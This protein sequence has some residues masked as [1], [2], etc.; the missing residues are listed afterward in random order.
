MLNESDKLAFGLLT[1]MPY[2]DLIDVLESCFKTLAKAVGMPGSVMDQLLEDDSLPMRVSIL[3][4]IAGIVEEGIEIAK[5][6]EK[7]KENK[8]VEFKGDVE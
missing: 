4:G 2:D 3:V 6:V 5:K 8:M 1:N 7:E